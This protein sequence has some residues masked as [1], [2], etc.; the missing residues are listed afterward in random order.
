MQD[1]ADNPN[2]RTQ[3][4]FLSYS[5]EVVEE[6]EK[7]LALVQIHSTGCLSKEEQ[8]TFV[9]HKGLNRVEEQNLNSFL[10]KEGYF[11]TE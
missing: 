11:G 9:R 1:S 5:Q 7:N 6:L 10:D 4:P 2:H 8:M 3:K